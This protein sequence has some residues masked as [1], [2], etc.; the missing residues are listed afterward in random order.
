MLAW[1]MKR[2][3]GAITLAGLQDRI[4]LVRG[5][6]VMLSTT[7][8]VLYEV[9]PKVLV[10]A[11][12]RNS[13]RFPPDFAFQLEWREVEDLRSRCVTL[14]GRGRHPKYPPYAFTEQGVAMLSSV[15][16]SVRAV[17]VNVAI[18]RAFVK[19]RETLSAYRDLAEKLAELER[20]LSSHDQG[21][22]TL[23][24]AIHQIMNPPEPPR[25]QIGFRVDEKRQNYGSD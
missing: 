21:I 17:E 3:E 20:R 10:Q 16:R 15:L 19:L 8:A 1:L 5:H 6:R 18:M 22:R 2:N 4:F 14:K 11:V 23:F 9:A 7:L 13:G 24:E 12:K 25:R